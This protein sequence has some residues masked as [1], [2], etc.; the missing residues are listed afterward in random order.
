MA[1]SAGS[2]PQPAVVE[3]TEAETTIRHK[4]LVEKMIF[5]SASATHVGL[6]RAINEDAV[7]GR[8]EIGLWAVADGVG[9]ADAGDRASAAI[10]AALSELPQS[11]SGL[12]SLEWAQQALRQVNAQLRHEALARGSRHGI[13]STVICL[14]IRDRRFFCLWVGDSRL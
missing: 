14:L 10:V 9:G 1:A 4:R 7:L 6:V 11:A 12:D 2:R 5:E 13:A 8:P 3:D